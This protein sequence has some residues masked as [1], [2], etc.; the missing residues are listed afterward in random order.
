MASEGQGNQQWK[1]GCFHS[2]DASDHTPEKLTE[3]IRTRFA[4]G[5][6]MRNQRFEPE[7]IGQLIGHL[8]HQAVLVSVNPS[9]SIIFCRIT[10]F[11]ALPVTVV[12]ISATNRT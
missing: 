4:I 5:R 6:E 9:S 10:N 8:S 1:E 7:E 3:S 2:G 11:W 12:G